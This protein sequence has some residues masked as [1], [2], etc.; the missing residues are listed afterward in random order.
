M[1]IKISNL[2][3]GVHSFD[4]NE[5]VKE[6]ELDEPFFGNALVNVK[7]NKLHN[8]IVLEADVSVK[9]K[10]ECDRCTA[11]F[12]SVLKTN[13]RMVYL[14]GIKPDGNDDANVTYLK[15]DSDKIS[16]D[17]DVR[18]YALLSVPMKKL[19]KEDCK[20]LC[21]NCGKDLNKGDCGC[22]NGKADDRWQPLMELKNKI[23]NN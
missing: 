9:A 12:D 5:D 11:D 19:C 17:A 1:I 4:F 3:E 8:Q 23:I 21:P 6:I 2:S 20:G 14:S 16:L 10:F 15:A 18:D 7:L 13:Y 22:T